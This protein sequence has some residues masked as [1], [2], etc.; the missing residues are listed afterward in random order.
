MCF[1]I[2]LINVKLRLLTW[3][4]KSNLQAHFHP[5]RLLISQIFSTLHSQKTYLEQQCLFGPENSFQFHPANFENFK[6]ETFQDKKCL[7]C[8]KTKFAGQ[9][10]FS[11][12][13]PAMFSNSNLRQISDYKSI[14][15]IIQSN[16]DSIRPFCSALCPSK[17]LF[18][19]N[20]KVFSKPYFHQNFVIFFVCVNDLTNQVSF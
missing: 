2:S 13:G 12:F 9:K 15:V 11:V 17:L 7:S 5:P 16:I 6:T 4:K 10:L 19:A 18:Q 3:E 14:S 20:I 8:K 1:L